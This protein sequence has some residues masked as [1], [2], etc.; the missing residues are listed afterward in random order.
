MARPRERVQS[1]VGGGVSIM[2]QDN[3]NYIRKHYLDVFNHTIESLF[4]E[5]TSCEQNIIVGGIYRPPNTSV[6][7]FIDEMNKL[8]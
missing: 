3:V 7:D 4:V 8:M 5:L 1:R 2:I 6:A